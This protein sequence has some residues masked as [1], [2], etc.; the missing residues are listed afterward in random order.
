MEHILVSGSIANDVLMQFNDSF[1]KHILPEHLNKLSVS[2]VI[3]KMQKS[4]WGTAQNIAYN[5][6]LL[7]WKSYTIMLWAVW[8]DFVVDTNLSKYIDYKYILKDKELFD[9]IKEFSNDFNNYNKQIVK[10]IDE[11]MP[12]EE[13][14]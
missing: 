5:I 10:T 6:W 7:W 4:P 12:P 13:A 14:A 2:F 3:D 9:E 11:L 8:Q 1:D